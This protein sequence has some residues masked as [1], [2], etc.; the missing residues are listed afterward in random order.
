VKVK[1]FER[2]TLPIFRSTFI[3]NITV[4]FINYVERKH[5]DFVKLCS[6]LLLYEGKWRPLTAWWKTTDITYRSFFSFEDLQLV[7]L[8]FIYVYYFCFGFLLYLC[9]PLYT[10]FVHLNSFSSILIFPFCFFRFFHHFLVSCCDL[11]T[12]LV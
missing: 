4:C 5:N 3:W 8:S 7:C 9:F 12:V 2:I 6:A 11:S 1:Y 10:S